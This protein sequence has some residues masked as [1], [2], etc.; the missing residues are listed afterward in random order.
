LSCQRGSQVDCTTDLSSGQTVPSAYEMHDALERRAPYNGEL[1]LTSLEPARDAVKV[2]SV[3]RWSERVSDVDRGDF[4]RCEPQERERLAGRTLQIPHA[5]VQPVRQLGLHTLT[6]TAADL[7]HLRPGWPGT[8]YLQSQLV[9]VR[10][11]RG[12]ELTQVHD[13]VP[14]DG[15]VI[16]D[17]VWGVSSVHHCKTG[18]VQG[19]KVAMA[20][21]CWECH[22][23]TRGCAGPLSQSACRAVGKRHQIEPRSA[24]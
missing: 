23:D 10:E 2:E 3:L 9:P 1:T 13:V 12:C 24:R 22:P 16:D 11:N 17:D 6:F 5:T 4:C 8:R 7:D 19:R 20:G 18:W 14:A 21:V 15:T